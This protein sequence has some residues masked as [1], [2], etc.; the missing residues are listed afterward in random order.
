MTTPCFYEG[1]NIYPYSDPMSIKPK[2][3]A[4]RFQQQVQ[5][6]VQER[7]NI[8]CRYDDSYKHQWGS[9]ATELDQADEESEMDLWKDCNDPDGDLWLS[10]IMQQRRSMTDQMSSRYAA[11]DEQRESH[12]LYMESQREA[13]CDRA[14]ELSEKR[15]EERAEAESQKRNR[16]VAANAEVQ[17]YVYKRRKRR[18]EKAAIEA[19]RLAKEK[20]LKKILK[21]QSRN[22]E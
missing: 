9:S 8:R 5:V 13:D 6:M 1:F 22:K 19:Q 7:K 14:M 18:E 21:S 12:R 4:R 15:D 11:D 10:G 3:R 20:H 17:V 16:I 2:S